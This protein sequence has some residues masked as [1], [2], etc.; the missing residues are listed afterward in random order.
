MMRKLLLSYIAAG[1]RG[2]GLWTWNGRLKGQEAMEYQLVNIQG[3]PSSRALAAGQV[4]QALQ[5]Y[6]FELWNSTHEP[7]VALLYSWENEAAAGRIF[8]QTPPFEC[9]FDENLNCKYFNARELNA[10]ALARMGWARALIDYGIPWVHIDETSLMSGILSSGELGPSLRT[11]VIPHTLA[12]NSSILPI[13]RAW[14]LGTY[15]HI[16]HRSS[17]Q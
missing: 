3:Q 1:Q 8:M 10:P 7:V 9:A 16:V 12:M 13:I 14:Q 15:T 4:A 6:R 11:L 2:I 17:Y 5:A